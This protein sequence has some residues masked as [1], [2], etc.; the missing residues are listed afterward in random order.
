[1]NGT[2]RGNAFRFDYHRTRAILK[3][4]RRVTA[5]LLQRRLGIGYGAV[6]QLGAE[7][8]RGQPGS[9]VRAEVDLVLNCRTL[10]LLLKI[11]HRPRGSS[12]IVIAK[13]DL[14]SFLTGDGVYSKITIRSIVGKS[15]GLNRAC[16][17]VRNAV[18]VSQASPQALHVAK[19]LIVLVSAAPTTLMGREIKIILSEFRRRVD[20][21]C[22]I[23]LGIH[24]LEPSKD[25]S[26]CVT[27]ISSQ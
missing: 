25:D 17:A 16:L 7:L 8:G 20:E 12:D 6:S 14:N 24:Y 19:R 13:D 3:A 18:G 1:M 23:S 22:T 9:E 15:S 5:S 2:T 21:T 27:V 26:L 11:W 10:Y 4:E